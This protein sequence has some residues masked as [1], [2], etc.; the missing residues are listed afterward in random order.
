MSAARTGQLAERKERNG[1]SR[2]NELTQMV[3][4]KKDLR[5]SCSSNGKGGGGGD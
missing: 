1:R 2:G 4:K 3:Q 5:E